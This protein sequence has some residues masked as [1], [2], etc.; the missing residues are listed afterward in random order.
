MRHNGDNE[1][2]NDVDHSAYI[3]EDLL[4]HMGDEMLKWQGALDT[5]LDHKFVFIWL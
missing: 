5:L 1:R 4:N 3:L 2:E